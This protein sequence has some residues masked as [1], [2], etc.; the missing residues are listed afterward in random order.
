[1]PLACTVRAS[2]GVH[3]YPLPQC[4]CVLQTLEASESTTCFPYERNRQEKENTPEYGVP[5]TVFQLNRATASALL[6][7]C[8]FLWHW[9]CYSNVNITVVFGGCRQFPIPQICFPV[10]PAFI[11]LGRVRDPT[12][13]ATSCLS[14]KDSCPRHRLPGGWAAVPD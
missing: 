1:M 6:V 12:A 9:H 3:R 4:A 13:S 5:Y 14:H 7:P 2:Y 8:F 10:F 11:D